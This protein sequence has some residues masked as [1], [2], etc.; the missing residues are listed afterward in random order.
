[1]DICEALQP[2]KWQSFSEQ[3]S[4]EG[5]MVSRSNQRC[6]AGPTLSWLPA[7]DIVRD[8]P[9]ACELRSKGIMNDDLEQRLSLYCVSSSQIVCDDLRSHFAPVSL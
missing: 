7:L 5:F 4:H 8:I 2:A 9:D 6:C 3:Y 1:M